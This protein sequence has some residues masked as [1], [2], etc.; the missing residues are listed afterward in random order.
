MSTSSLLGALLKD[1]EELKDTYVYELK[2]LTLYGSG[3]LYIGIANNPN[4]REKDH[5]EGRGSTSKKSFVVMEIITGP[6]KKSE[7]RIAE[8]QRLID[9]YHQYKQLPLYNNNLATMRRLGLDTN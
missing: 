9:H 1:T 5:R 2:G 6:I 7:A 4:E 3:V 8:D